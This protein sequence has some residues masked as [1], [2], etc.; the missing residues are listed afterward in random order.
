LF[1]CGNL[2]M[3]TY[4]KW[5]YLFTPSSV[6]VI[7]ASNT[8]G[9]WGFDITRHLLTSRAYK[10]YLVNTTIP[11][12]LG[13][14]TYTSVTDI[15]GPVDLAVIAVPA[16][17]VIPVFRE[18]ARKE[19]KTAVVISGGFGETGEQGLI[20]EAELV[21][22]AQRAGIRFVGP[23]SLGH[24]NTSLP[25]TTIAQIEDIAPGPVAL[26]SQSGN[27]GA[28][29]IYNGMVSEIGFSKF[30][31]TGNEADLHLEDYLEYLAQD[32][33]TKIITAYI[34]G[35]REGRRFFQLAKKITTN[36]PIVAIKAGRTK[37]SAQAVRSHTATLA[38]SDAVYAAAFRQSGV[39]RVEDDDELCDVVAA[40]LNQ[41]LPRGNRIGI[42]TIGGGMGVVAAEACEREGLEIAPLSPSTLKKLD[43]FLP[44]RWSHANPVD[45]AGISTTESS[46]IFSS[47]WA[48]MEDKNIDAILLQVP[49]A[50]NTSYL[51]NIFSTEE[52]GAFRKIEKRN[53]NMLRQKLKGYG[54]PVF[55]VKTPNES[56]TGQW[57]SSSLRREGIL[58]YS[59][60]R[61]VA[62]VLHHLIWYADYLGG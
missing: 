12:V 35:L 46:A 20:L 5:Q 22:I 27:M 16:S 62:R 10:V 24:A 45:L 32:E 31:S 23:N 37:R 43:A 3:N 61:R 60:P 52:I 56:G 28:R 57:G 47:L 29:I 41:P 51:S 25:I 38:G 14:K 11:E 4:N 19:V 53:L 18:C 9:S 13:R 42:L 2:I 55:R 36:K 54:K 6:A 59:N 33:N 26:I 48:L 49:M 8:L 21:G 7:G 39:I 44:P 58:T 34:E 50:V 15:P 40:L 30:I 17:K 1:E